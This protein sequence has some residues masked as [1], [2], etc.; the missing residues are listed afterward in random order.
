MVFI[1]TLYTHHISIFSLIIGIIDRLV[2]TLRESV[3]KY[4][5]ITGHR[6]DNIKYVMKSIIAI[7]HTLFYCGYFPVRFF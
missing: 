5:D 1:L 6:T 3:E 4:Y 7:Y 2:G